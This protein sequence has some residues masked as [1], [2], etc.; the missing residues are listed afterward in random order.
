MLVNDALAVAPLQPPESTR[1][2]VY[3]YYLED[4]VMSLIY[5]I[6]I[7]IVAQMFIYCGLVF[8]SG[9]L[10]PNLLTPVYHLIPDSNFRLLFSTFTLML[11]GN[12]LF[13]RLYS[14]Q[15]VLIAGIVSTVIGICIVNVGG[16]IIERKAPSVLMAVGVTVL[17][18]G[19]IV[20]VYA[21]SRL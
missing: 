4:L 10:L 17:V 12:F 13:Q 20:C 8:M 2:A 9:K 21:R 5:A 16:L 19:A 15:P 14:L 1:Y 11:I 6:G 18:T 7:A 3:R